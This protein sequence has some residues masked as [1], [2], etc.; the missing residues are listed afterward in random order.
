MPAPHLEELADRI[1]AEMSLEERLCL[2]AGRD[3]WHTNAVER[4]GLASLHLS[5]GPSGV[6]GART[7]GATSASFPCGIALGATFDPGLAFE[8]GAAL[9]F[10]AR[11]KGAHVV[12]GPTVNLH[13]HPLGGRHFE[14][15]SEDPLLT[16][17]L[18]VSYVEGLQSNGVAAT[19]KHYVCNDTEHER[20]TISSEVDE[21]TLRELYLV[22][23]E[24]AVTRAGAWAV[25]AAYNRIG[26][27][28][29]AEH[30]VLIGQVLRAEWG[31][32]GVVVSDWYGT[33]STVASALAGLDLEMP[34]PPAH[35]GKRLAKAVAS[36]EVPVDVLDAKVRRLLVLAGRTGAL[37]R[38]GGPSPTGGHTTSPEEPARLA[39]TIAVESF[40]LL[41]NEAPRGGS[42]PLLPLDVRGA[43]T[44]ALI[45]PNAERT[46]IQGGGSARVQPSAPVSVLAGMRARLAPA[47]ISVT[48]SPGCTIERATPPLS[49][50]LELAYFAGPAASG[51]P[52][53]TEKTLGSSLIWL[54][55]P[56]PGEE[57]LAAGAFSVRCATTLV[58]GPGAGGAWR[59]SLVCVGTAQL[60]IDG[61]VVVDASDPDLL[62]PGKAF[63]GMGCE[64]V[65]AVAELEEGRAY[66]LVATYRVLADSPVAGLVVGA[67]PPT[68]GPDEM[69]AD[70]VACA[71]AADLAVVVVGTNGEWETEG[72]DRE[73]MD[74]PGRQD[75]LVSRVVAANPRT[76]VL[77]NAGS[78]V[79]MPWARDV[80]ALAQIWFGGQ[81]IG[82]AVADVL[83]GD[84]DPGGRLPTTLPVALTDTPA[85]GSYPG[86]G[87]LERYDEGLLMGY[88]HY[89]TNGVEPAFAFG[90]GLSY[91]TFELRDLSI[92]VK[93]P[94][95]GSGHDRL[96][97]AIGLEVENTGN[98]AG[99]EVV[100]CFLHPL[101]PVPGAAAQQLAAFEK[102]HLA[103]GE[104][105]RVT[106]ELS[107]RSFSHFDTAL[108]RFV[109][110]PGRFEIRVG[111]SSREID[112]TAVVEIPPAS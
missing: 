8:L 1:C 15:Y 42:A 25:M 19:V 83:S 72:H 3:L 6:R 55:D 63:F 80:A 112:L 88:R 71:A 41:R 11:A 64:E 21:R 103:A 99:T 101:A 86:Q 93:V 65:A 30:E 92:A 73:V 85:F 37:E 9:A 50:E 2:V 17:E 38:A 27:V 111:R 49:G 28:Y 100:Q 90:H 89:D 46:A 5:D 68:A 69:M 7:V 82:A 110:D 95:V 106:L 61:A 24:A 51:E 79:T 78:P 105:T 91:T 43:R 32:D 47:G 70:A 102:V 96:A 109:V 66:D 54:G 33:K 77:V 97:V 48:H 52:L 14:S 84:R 59:F 108:H 58:A 76:V 12:L 94:E 81:E 53:A 62:T 26:G 29:A 10:E 57:G 35:F 87:G 107:E 45:G 67:A 31:F 36:G 60:E 104:S 44:V 34:G 22:P 39:R 75:E 16:A 20:H 18:A 4:L 13:R 40:T 23:F 56:V 74:L 98:R